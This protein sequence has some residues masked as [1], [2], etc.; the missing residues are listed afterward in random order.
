MSQLLRV[1]R[2]EQ[3]CDVE[4]QLKLSGTGTYFLVPLIE[5]AHQFL[6][7][8]NMTQIEHSLLSSNLK[9]TQDK[10]TT[11]L[12]P[13]TYLIITTITESSLEGF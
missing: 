1:W 7:R 5:L 13:C 3:G 11:V 6:T 9:G 8:C 2:I 12:L 10:T 4:T